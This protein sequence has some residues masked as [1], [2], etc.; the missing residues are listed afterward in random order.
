MSELN[1]EFARIE[2]EEDV[3]PEKVDADG[4]WQRINI[5]ILY[6]GILRGVVLLCDLNYLIAIYCCPSG[7]ACIISR[8]LFINLGFNCMDSGFSDFYT[9]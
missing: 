2:S 8:V 1:S 9:N 5:A 3:D 4:F 7:F 6:R